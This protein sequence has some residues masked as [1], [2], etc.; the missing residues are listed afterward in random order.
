MVKRTIIFVILI[1]LPAAGGRSFA[2]N[3]SFD[4]HA[5]D[6]NFPGMSCAIIEDFDGDGDPDIVGGSEGTPYNTSKGIVWW[7]NEGGNPLTWTR[8]LIDYYFDNVMSVEAADL[9]DDGF[10]DIVA[11]SWNDHQ[12]AWYENSGGTVPTWTKRVIRNS[13][14]NAHDARCLDMD[15]DGDLDVVGINSTPGSV[16]VCYSDGAVPPSWT[17]QT[18]TSSFAGGKVVSLLD[19]DH[20][21]DPDIVG[22]AMDAHTLAWWE[23]QGDIR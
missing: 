3:L 12:I 18:V 17:T 19:F 4:S 21:G 5:V 10:S 15:Q 6:L 13:F 20:D 16:V 23:N 7:R 14:T 11:T 8:Y 1:L 2:Q 22:G 9:N